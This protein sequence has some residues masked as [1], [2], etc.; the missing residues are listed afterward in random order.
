MQSL[1][2]N[3]EENTPQVFDVTI[4]DFPELV[5]QQSQSTLVLID[6]W[7]PWCGPCKTLTPILEGLVKQYDGAVVLAKINIDEEQHI[8]A[9]FQVRSV[10]TVFVMKDGNVVDGFMGVQPENAIKTMLSKHVEL[11]GEDQLDA[12]DT[13]IA[14]N[15]IDD[16]VAALKQEDSDEGRIRLAKLYLNLGS[17]EDAKELLGAVGKSEHGSPEYKSAIA[18]LH[19]Q[20]IAQNSPSQRDLLEAIENN[21]KDW[22]SRYQLAAF[23]LINGMLEQALAHLMQIVKSDRSFNDDAGRKGLIMAFDVIGSEN[24]LVGKY[25]RLLAITLN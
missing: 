17:Y 15:R 18:T 2:L 5:L 25:R 23:L 1:E 19:F 10:P 14:Q 3:L 8:A 4:E 13:L 20:E 11:P 6:F 9:Q 21:P 12:I 24:E 16:A 22:N 7:A